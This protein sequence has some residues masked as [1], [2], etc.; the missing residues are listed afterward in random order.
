M[1]FQELEGHQVIP[2]FAVHQHP[3]EGPSLNPIHFLSDCFPIQELCQLK[4]L[5]S[6]VQLQHSNFGL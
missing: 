3:T 4:Q 1:S 5:G 6:Q 2:A